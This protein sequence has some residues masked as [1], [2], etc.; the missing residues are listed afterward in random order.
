[1]GATKLEQHGTRSIDAP[2]SDCPKM[3]QCKNSNVYA[4]VPA[5]SSSVEWVWN[6]FRSMFTRLFH[7][8]HVFQ[9]KLATMRRDQGHLFRNRARLQTAASEFLS[10]TSDRYHALQQRLAEKRD[11]FNHVTQVGRELPFSLAEFRD[12]LRQLLDG[13]QGYTRCHYC[14]RPLNIITL[15]LDHMVP[16]AQGGEL[17]WSNLC[18]AC[19]PCNQMKGNTTAAT[20]VRVLAF[21]ETLPPFDGESLRNRLQMATKLA[22]DN[23]R[24][25]AQ[26]AG[27]GHGQGESANG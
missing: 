26:R 18:V 24:M 2:F 4:A 6:S 17:G 16:L 27:A 1:V 23:R 7:V 13:E 14:G 20:F 25:K 11:R 12:R 22:I 21:I 15:Q 8:F 19:E 5:C 9:R 10:I 3:V